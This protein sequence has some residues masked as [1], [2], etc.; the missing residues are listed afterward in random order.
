M[1]IEIPMDLCKKRYI[2]LRDCIRVFTNH[3]V[4]KCDDTAMKR[5][6]FRHDHFSFLKNYKM[7][8]G[9]DRRFL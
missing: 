3:Q 8:T 5:S 7:M 9:G 1:K 4:I 2:V 6:V